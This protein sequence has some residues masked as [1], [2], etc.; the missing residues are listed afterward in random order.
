MDSLCET[1]F[2][3]WVLRFHYSSIRWFQSEIEK[4]IS[5][6][7]GKSTRRQRPT[8]THIRDYNSLLQNKPVREKKNQGVADKSNIVPVINYA[9]RTGKLEE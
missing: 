6:T 8:G 7:R 3:P 9:P 5:R 4:I 2:S 1:C